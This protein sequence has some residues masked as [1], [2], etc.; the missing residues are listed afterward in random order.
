MLILRKVRLSKGQLCPAGLGKRLGQGRTAL[1]L[2]A[3]ARIRK[4]KNTPLLTSKKNQNKGKRLSKLQEQNTG[5]LAK[6]HFSRHGNLDRH[7]DFKK[8]IFVSVSFLS[9]IAAYKITFHFA[10]RVQYLLLRDGETDGQKNYRVGFLLLT[11]F[12][13]YHSAQYI[14]PSIQ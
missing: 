9:L 8:I 5:Q 6:T 4:N 3:G 1:E 7:L 13:V 14:I 11:I 2:P 12:F 10:H